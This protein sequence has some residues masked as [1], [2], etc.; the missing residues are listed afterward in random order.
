MKKYYAEIF[1]HGKQGDDFH[2]LLENSKTVSEALNKWATV[3][4]EEAK[5]LIFL[6]EQFK[7]KEVEA[8]ADT[9]MIQFIGEESLLKPLV[10]TEILSHFDEF[11]ED[12]ECCC[13]EEECCDVCEKHCGVWRL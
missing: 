2:H 10:D 4:Q 3:M 5:R 1:V 12:E 6:S 13:S 11:E 8:E 7:D 9:H